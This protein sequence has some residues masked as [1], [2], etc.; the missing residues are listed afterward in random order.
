MNRKLFE[1]FGRIGGRKRARKLSPERRSEIATHAARAR[2]KKNEK[3][4]SLMPSVRFS[5]LS[6]E[7]HAYLE[8]ILLDGGL[9]D[10]KRIYESSQF[11]TVSSAW[12]R[13]D[14]PAGRRERQVKRRYR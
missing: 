13:N 3:Q 11:T 12:C 5:A 1:N 9:A 4:Q 6:L 7:E 8:E 2:W 10:W 14:D